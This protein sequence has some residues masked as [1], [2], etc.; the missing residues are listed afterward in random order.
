[1]KKKKKKKKLRK[2][3]RQK[4]R[5]VRIKLLGKRRS[6]KRRKTKYKKNKRKLTNNLKLLSFLSFFKPKIIFNFKKIYKKITT[7]IVKKNQRFQEK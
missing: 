3:S 6:S 7:P 1:M 4:I 2:K 5:K